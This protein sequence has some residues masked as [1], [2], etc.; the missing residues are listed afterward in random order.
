MRYR[1][2]VCNREFVDLIRGVLG[3]KPLPCPRYR[4]SR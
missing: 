1:R 3:L 4:A 2:R